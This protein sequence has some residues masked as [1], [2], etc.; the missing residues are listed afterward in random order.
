MKLSAYFVFI[1]LV[2]ACS[3]PSKVTPPVK[4]EADVA[5][6]KSPSPTRT[7]LFI[8]DGM[9]V[10]AVSGTAYLNDKKLQMLEMPE[11][12]W[13]STHSYE[14]MTT[15]SAASAT[16]LS[17]G[18]KTHFNGVSVTP[19]TKDIEETEPS[20]HLESFFEI[21]KKKGLGRGVVSTSRVVHATPAAFYAHRSTRKSYEKIAEDM[22]NSDLDVVLGAGWKYFRSRKDGLDLVSK[23][24]ESGYDYFESPEDLEAFEATSKKAVGLFYKGDMPF[25]VDEK[26][27]V[28]L[29]K[30]VDSAIKILDRGHPEGWVLMVEG[31]FIDWC[32]HAM[33]ANCTF[34]ET[35]DFDDAIGVGRRYAKTRAQNDT[36][37]V[38][39]ADH[40]TGGLSIIDPPYAKRFSDRIDKA[41]LDATPI[42]NFG[43]G[44]FLSPK[45][46][47]PENKE[48]I[49]TF[50]SM[51]VASNLVWAE[52]GR[53]YA[54]HTANFVPIF[55][56][57]PT[58]E[59]V[60]K[61][62]DNATLGLRLKE[63]VSGNQTGQR[64]AP[65]SETP[66]NIVLF[67]G[68][69]MGIPSVT[70]GFYD[71]GKSHMMSLDEHGIVVPQASDRLVPDSASTA[72]SLSTG[73]LHK[74]GELAFSDADPTPE[75]IIERAA[76]SGKSV[77][78]ITT[79]EI[80]HA[81]PAAF[82]AHQSSRNKTKEIAKDLLNFETR[83]G[84]KIDVLLG[85]GHTII[86]PHISALEAQGYEVSQSW[87][88][89]SK[90]PIIGVFAPGALPNMTEKKTKKTG[91]PTLAE[92]VSF[93]IDGLSKN[94]KGYVLIIEGGQIDHLLHEFRNSELMA[95]IDEFDNAI[96]VAAKKVDAQTLIVVTADHDHTMSVLDNHY[97]FETGRC[98]AAKRCGGK[99]T[100]TDQMTSFK[101]SELQGKYTPKVIL[102][103]A[104]LI[105]A[106]QDP[107][108][109][110]GH[111]PT[112]KGS[113]SA[114]FVPLF[115]RGPGSEY[116]RG[117]QTQVQV[118]QRLNA[119]VDPKADF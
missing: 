98:G 97:A 31:S 110:K 108:P 92:M 100:Y 115:A 39:T 67:I 88:P 24:K 68:D 57:G 43:L 93:A 33:R 64:G 22:V 104:W 95:E 40:E 12:G 46:V 59:Y 86:A 5:K 87:P 34:M 81:T 48:L 42:K 10:G 99:Y 85:G 60:S 7:I 82:Y 14:F 26:R 47:A 84:K 55:A 65:N 15:D 114:N 27:T 109:G 6:T 117:F 94:E 73:Q 111:T 89:K 101:T 4:T 112:I 37:I 62:R 74:R 29:P 96:S 52:K 35:K 105:R 63:V 38:A 1:L 119:F 83:T 9:G 23:L 58:A 49:A 61:S 75:T 25:I 69:G 45:K 80:T 30:M 44:S 70:V 21:A 113:H 79:V 103:Y 36:L 32:E 18:E 20:H 72:S 107:V 53:F 116:L 3:G 76:K 90:G 8:G 71:N 51:S 16:A 102:Q 118:G 2:S 28:S 77:G 13:M 56:E 41:S 91:I 11:F 19:G 54:A 78:I 50:G 66:K 17:T 106:A